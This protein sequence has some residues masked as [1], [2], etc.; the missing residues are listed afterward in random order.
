MMT[1]K[2]STDMDVDYPDEEKIPIPKY[3]LMEIKQIKEGEE[4]LAGAIGTLIGFWFTT[5]FFAFYPFNFSDEKNMPMIMAHPVTF[6]AF[7][8]IAFGSS[9][10]CY[11]LLLQKHKE[12]ESG[13]LGQILNQ[14]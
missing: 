11:Y 10:Y 5:L 1:E 12:Q 14:I 8:F 2:P 6:G 3:I 7:F 13:S 9:I 4:L